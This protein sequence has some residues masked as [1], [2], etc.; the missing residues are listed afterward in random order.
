VHGVQNAAVDRFKAIA[1]IWQRPRY[2]NA[3]RVIKVSGTHLIVNVYMSYGTDI[4]KCPFEGYYLQNICSFECGCLYNLT[5]KIR[6][7]IEL[8][9]L[10]RMG[11]LH[12]I[13][14]LLIIPR[15]TNFRLI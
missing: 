12:A 1:R 5:Q 13:Y 3:H 9:F 10:R 11:F 15:M 8:Q 14:N 7:E 2:D 6:S 4:H